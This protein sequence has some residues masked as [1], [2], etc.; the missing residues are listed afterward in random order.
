MYE[1]AIKNDFISIEEIQMSIENKFFST[2]F[3]N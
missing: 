2:N 1:Y 3:L